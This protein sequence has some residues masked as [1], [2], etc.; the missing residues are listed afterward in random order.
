LDAYTISF[1]GKMTTINQK[2]NEMK[3]AVMD[4]LFMEDMETI[5]NDFKSVDSEGW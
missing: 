4:N 3:F 5:S 2:I 1:K